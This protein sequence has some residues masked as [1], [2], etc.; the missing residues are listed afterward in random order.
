M[1]TTNFTLMELLDR[2]HPL[3]R[4]MAHEAPGAFHPSMLV[5]ELAREAAEAQEAALAREIEAAKQA[6]AAELAAIESA[7]REAAARASPSSS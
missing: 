4:R 1:I 5:A 3:L 6:L 7:K 2:N